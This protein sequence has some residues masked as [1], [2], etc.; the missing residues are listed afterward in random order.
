MAALPI[1]DTIRSL[2]QSKNLSQRAAAKELGMSHVHLN[3][4]ENGHVSPT[5]KCLEKFSDAWGQDVYLLAI[6]EV[7]R[8]MAGDFKRMLG[9][10]K[11]RK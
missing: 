6:D 9:S 4:I 2:R 8:Q 11:L 3:N 10:G 5:L 7:K 1:G